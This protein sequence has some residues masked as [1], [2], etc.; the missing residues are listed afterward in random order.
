MVFSAERE[1]ERETA[2]VTKI[3]DSGQTFHIFIFTLANTH[4]AAWNTTLLAILEK[5]GWLLCSQPNL[6][7]SSPS[8]QPSAGLS[9][10]CLEV[11]SFTIPLSALPIFK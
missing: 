2:R 4:C 8:A 7:V 5:S 6:A 1:R 9:A 3:A 11:N 10:A